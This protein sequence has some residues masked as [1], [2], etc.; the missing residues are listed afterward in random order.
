MINQVGIWNKKGVSAV[1]ILQASEMTPD[2]ISRIE[3]GDYSLI[4][5]SPEALMQKRWLHL[6]QKFDEQIIVVACDEVHCLIQWGEQF[7]PSYKKVSILRS[8]L[9]TVPF[10]LLSA[11][12][13]ET[14]RKQ[15]CRLLLLSESEVSTTAILPDRPNL[16]FH[17]HA[18][19]KYFQIELGW[20][21]EH[22]VKG[23]KD[24]EKVIVYCRY[25]EH[26]EDIYAWLC[27]KLGYLKVPKVPLKDR[28]LTMYHGNITVEHERE[29]AQEFPKPAS[30]LRCIV[31]TIAFGMGVDIPD[32]R[33]VVHWGTPKTSLNYWQEVGR[34][35][36]DGQKG[37][38]H[39]YAI[40][41]IMVPRQTDKD[42]LDLCKEVANGACIR[43]GVLSC[44][45]LPDMDIAALD[46]LKAR[47]PRTEQCAEDCSCELCTCCSNCRKREPS[48]DP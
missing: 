4:F 32:V 48:V 39:L 29:V 36:R 21:A 7:R 11:T 43:C 46:A 19:V 23:M 1:S 45:I 42:M 28:I 34:C 17:Y 9:T 8:Y 33:Y 14:M 26:L 20:L 12:V 16:F 24:A 5:A 15:I 6:A 37:N 35:S 25:M 10:L 3:Q 31:S 47:A 41:G 30:R 2:Q 22:L 38:A 44:L 13:T 18:D 40:G 27:T